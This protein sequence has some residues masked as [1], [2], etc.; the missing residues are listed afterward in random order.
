MKKTY[1]HLTMWALGALLIGLVLALG[2]TLGFA[3]EAGDLAGETL[4]GLV[5]EP[6]DAVDGALMNDDAEPQ[7]EPNEEFPDQMVD[8]SADESGEE[9]AD[10]AVDEGAV[11]AAN[12]T[13]T[14]PDNQTVS[15]VVERPGDRSR[16]RMTERSD[17][18]TT[19]RSR[20]RTRGGS[21]DENAHPPA[22]G[23]GGMAAEYVVITRNNIFS[24]TRQ[25]WRPTPPTPTTP[26]VVT[27]PEA[28]YILRGIVAE[29]D[30][31]KALVQ[32]N[33]NGGVLWLHVGDEIAQGKI[34]SLTL[35]TLE[36]ES[37]EKTTMVAMGQDLQGG[38]GALN[39]SDMSQW[40]QSS[41]SSSRRTRD[42]GRSSGGR[43][44]RGRF[45]GDR[46]FQPSAPTTSSEEP[47]T[48]DAAELLRRL[49]ER[50]Q[51]QLGN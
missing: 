14:E 41:Y 30:T 10:E 48:G 12:E 7:N 18:S 45:S 25:P 34:K 37:G 4:T 23:P 51:Q 27:P 26:T 40:S 16:S 50:R 42:E 21:R 1:R 35:D 44:D 36:Y 22:S 24:P 33:Q 2:P 28:Y 8:E 29:N 31:F 39:I 15:Q 13:T 49:M 5:D 9:P 46:S 32:D 19:G 20:D 11:E 6:N 38:R 17:D 47:V 43:S 3:Q